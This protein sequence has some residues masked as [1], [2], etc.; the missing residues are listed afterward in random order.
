M[1]NYVINTDKQMHTLWEAL[2]NNRKKRRLENFKKWLDTDIYHES[3]LDL[4]MK[5]KDILENLFFE[6]KE[7][8]ESYGHVIQDEKRLRDTVASMIYKESENGLR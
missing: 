8:L 4:K 7:L 5:V 6:T 3:N 2:E 1:S